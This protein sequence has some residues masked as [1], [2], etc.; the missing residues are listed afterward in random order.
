MNDPLD[1]NEALAGRTP[2]APCWFCLGFT[3]LMLI[4]WAW[5]S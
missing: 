3:A 5:L 4:T 2:P 1:L